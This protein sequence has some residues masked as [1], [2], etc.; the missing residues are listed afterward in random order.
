[1]AHNNKRL[2][3]RLR[4]DFHF[5]LLS[6]FFGIVLSEL[7]AYMPD[8]FL[9]YLLGWSGSII[10]AIAL[11]KICLLGEKILKTIRKL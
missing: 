1:M 8:L 7:G 2:T 4:N 6:I 5:Y 10:G 3:K 11:I 9:G